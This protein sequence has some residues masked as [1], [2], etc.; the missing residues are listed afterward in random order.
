MNSCK[1]RFLGLVVTTLFITSLIANPMEI[2]KKEA[3][4][5]I[6]KSEL[7]T[8]DVSKVILGIG[9]GSLMAKEGEVVAKTASNSFL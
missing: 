8:D 5:V 1:F 4:S 7:K 3:S 2:T 9:G 6:N